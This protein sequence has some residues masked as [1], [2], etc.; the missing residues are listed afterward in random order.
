MDGSGAS[1][2]SKPTIEPRNDVDF[3][4]RG[5]IPRYW[6]AG[7][8]FKTRFFDAFSTLFPEGEKFFISCVRDYRDRI[9]DPVLLEDVKNFMR[10]EGQ[11]GRVH[12]EFNERLSRQGIRVDRIEAKCRAIFGFF[13]RMLPAYWTLAQTAAVEHMTAIMAHGFAQNHV[14]RGADARMRA[15][16]TWHGVEEIEHKAVAFDV[17]RKV[18]KVGWFMRCLTM[19]EVSIFF[20]VH[21]FLIMRHM[22]RVDGYG[23]RQRVGLWLRGL[24]WLYGPGGVYMPLMGSYFA[25]YKPGFHPWQDERL[26]PYWRWVESYKRDHDAIAAGEAA[27]AG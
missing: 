19:L 18:A 24:W 25:Y 13:R 9:E 22:F 2:V 27:S 20:P 26:G 21:T 15:L 5:D 3:D 12:S 17:M 11:H 23:F 7:D 10:Q 14:L 1:A 6:F 16:Y 8:P 4:L